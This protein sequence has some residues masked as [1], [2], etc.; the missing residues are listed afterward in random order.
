MADWRKLIENIAPTLATAVAPPFGGIALK[1]VQLALGLGEG[2]KEEEIARVLATASPEQI[3][4]LK[5]A[6]QDYRLNLERLGI[7]REKIAADDRDSARKRQIATGDKTPQMIGLITIICYCAVQ[8]YILNHVIPPEN[9]EIVMRS[10]GTLDALIG[11]VANY[12]LG[13]SASSR[14]KDKTINKLS[15]T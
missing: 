8:W 6:E 5:K 14:E 15:E 2:T 4:A 7:D 9:R 11:V 1:A 10:L 13:S 3:I 12:F